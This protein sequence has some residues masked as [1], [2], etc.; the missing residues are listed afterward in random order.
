MEQYPQQEKMYVDYK[1]LK[2]KVLNKEI[3]FKVVIDLLFKADQSTSSR[4][5]LYDNEQFL[6]DE[7]IIK[8]IEDQDKEIQNGYYRI[9]SLS[10]FHVAQNEVVKGNADEGLEKFRESLVCELKRLSHPDN[11]AYKRGSIAYLEKDIA[12]LEDSIDRLEEGRNKEILVN[13]LEGLKTRGYP[14]YLADYSK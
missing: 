6:T 9:L 7:E 12:T 14:D 4:E 1:E 5:A 2:S 3:D 10:H 11:I 8:Y 13:M